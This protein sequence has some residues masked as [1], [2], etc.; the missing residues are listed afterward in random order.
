[1]P[2]GPIALHQ[3]RVGLVCRAPGSRIGTAC[4]RR[5]QLREQVATLRRHLVELIRGHQHAA[6]QPGEQCKRVAPARRSGRG[7]GRAAG[8]SRGRPATGCRCRNCGPSGRAAATRPNSGR[9]SS[10][11][12]RGRCASRRQSPTGA[13]SGAPQQSH[14]ASP[15][16]SRISL[17]IRIQMAMRLRPSSCQHALR[18]V[19]RSM[20]RCMKSVLK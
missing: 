7:S 1:M 8:C 17:A 12:Y 9:S 5:H 4:R 2:C 20:P 16:S 13:Q 18:R 15:I 19:R 11:R 6:S 3:H 10:R 14:S